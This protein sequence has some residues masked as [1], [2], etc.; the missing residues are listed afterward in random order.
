MTISD[1]TALLIALDRTL[2]SPLAPEVLALGHRLRLRLARRPTVA[3]VG[4]SDCG[5]PDLSIFLTADPRLAALDLREIVIHDAAPPHDLAAALAAITPQLAVWCARSFSPTDLDRWSRVP[6]S[7]RDQSFL[8]VTSVEP[9]SAL[10]LADHLADEFRDIFVRPSLPIPTHPAQHWPDPKVARAIAQAILHQITL[11]Q[12]ALFDNVHLFLSRYAAAA[13]DPPMASALDRI[14][15]TLTLRT[16]GLIPLLD[17]PALD[18]A[19]AILSHCTACIEAMVPLA[20]G[21]TGPLF[22]DILAAADSLILMQIEGGEA[23][24]ADA[25]ALLLQLRREIAVSG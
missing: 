12:D 1:T 2:A 23:A 20:T 18:R 8:V 15:A 7:L 13:P 24:A 25:L 9:T 16:R 22:D 3:I 6:Q 4:H 11:G 21:Q 19:S 14:H 17:L 5:Q 10:S